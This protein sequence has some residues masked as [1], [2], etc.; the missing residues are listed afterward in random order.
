MCVYPRLFTKW[1]KTRQKGERREQAE[2]VAAVASATVRH[3][4]FILCPDVD[5]ILWECLPQ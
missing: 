4:L 3:K 5:I 2:W 1:H